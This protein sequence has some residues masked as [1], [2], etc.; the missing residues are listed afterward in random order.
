MPDNENKLSAKAIAYGFATFAAYCLVGSLIM[1]TN[2]SLGGVLITMHPLMLVISGYVTG[3]HAKRHGALNALVSGALAP[4]VL[5]YTVP[6]ILLANAETEI[7]NFTLIGTGITFLFGHV[8][9]LVLLEGVG[10]SIFGG[11]LWQLQHD[12]V[13]QKWWRTLFILFF[14]R[15]YTVI[16]LA[17][18]IGILLTAAETIVVYP[19]FV[20][21][22][23]PH[24]R[25][26][27]GHKYTIHPQDFINDVLIPMM[28]Y[29]MNTPGFYLLVT[30]LFGLVVK[31]IDREK[32]IKK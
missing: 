29:V 28:L 4:L 25:D 1:L 18:V 12:P 27:M 21:T 32:K 8:G 15:R 16:V 10:L 2:I 26:L 31:V 23:H 14:G 19:N 5:I 17:I 20:A 30:G 13:R 22:G 9:L 11:N 24:A 7:G 3:Y 6:L